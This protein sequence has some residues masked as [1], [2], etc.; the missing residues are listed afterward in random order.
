MHFYDLVKQPHILDETNK[1]QIIS[2]EYYYRCFK[3]MEIPIPTFV[4]LNR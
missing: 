3:N 4:K 2:K 1:Q